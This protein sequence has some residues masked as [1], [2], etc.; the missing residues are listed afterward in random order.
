MSDSPPS[1]ITS[2][3]ENSLNEHSGYKVEPHRSFTAVLS[4]SLLK[5]TIKTPP[6]CT[7]PRGVGISVCS[8]SSKLGHI[9]LNFYLSSYPRWYGYGYRPSSVEVIISEMLTLTSNLDPFCKANQI[10]EKLKRGFFLLQ[11]RFTPRDWWPGYYLGHRQRLSF[12]KTK[13]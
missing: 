12:N 4:E 13:R 3:S 11:T 9:K 1:T 6:L 10:L 5:A 8:H 7:P 2:A